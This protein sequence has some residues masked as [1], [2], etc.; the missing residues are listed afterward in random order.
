MA[1]LIVGAVCG[2]GAVRAQTTGTTA[3]VRDYGA[4]GDGVANDSLAIQRA[5][6][7]VGAS[8]G[9]TVLFPAGVYEAMGVKQGSNVQFLGMD[10]ATL[11]HRNGI[12]STPIVVGRTTTTSGTITAGSSTVTVG[13]AN[14][15]VPGAIIGL[16]GAGGPSWMQRTTLS[17]PVGATG[18][19]LILKDGEGW[20]ENN[21]NFLWVENELISYK[22]M[23]GNRLLNVLR[24]RH[25]TKAV[26]H[27]GGS[28][29]S[30]AQRLIARVESV[31][32]STV[33]LDRP[34]VRTVRNAELTVGSVN[35]SVRGLVIDGSRIANPDSP[36]SS[37]ISLL[38]ELAH[39]VTVENNSFR[40]SG[41]GAVFL[42]QGTRASLIS[43]NFIWDG[44]HPQ[45]GWGAGVWLYRGATSNTVRG[46]TIGG[47]SNLGVMIDD[48][49]N[50]SSEWDASSDDNI[51]VLN[52]VDMSAVPQQAAIAV[53][54]SNRN[55]IAENQL[56]STARGIS[57][58][59]SIQGARPGQSEGNLVR[60]NYLSSHDTGLFV[61]G[62]Y[63]TF[64]G[65][66]I[67]LT[68]NPVV[69][70]G[71]GNTFS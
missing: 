10:G 47:D 58:Q 37:P 6:D 15:V 25:G 71:T 62:S 50:T 29:V 59:R 4:V 61:T 34:A 5:N 28:S 56:R 35:M 32:G 2:V 18:G 38:Y 43:D 31:T 40:N 20:R 7:A 22:G 13:S 63:N 55:E 11:R 48:R 70:M 16:R 65:N 49:T 3:N 44:G 1:V 60:D 66:V 8:G 46:N 68:A 26:S 19:M 9:G 23:S 39:G 21:R 64:V 36:S 12:S 69:D 17:F 30:Q 53:W 52:S 41:H 57:V 33:Q 27:A 51:I 45:H 42:D 24:G 67:E 14:R 54:G